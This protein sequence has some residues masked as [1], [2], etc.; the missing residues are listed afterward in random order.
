MKI[1]TQENHRRI[2]IVDDNPSIHSDFRKLLAEPGAE[3]AADLD[4]AA[5]DLFGQGASQSERPFFA[6]SSAFQGQEGL[7]KVREATASGQP[8]AVAFVD[9]RMPPGW[10]GIET[11]IRLWEADPDLQIVIC[12]AY[13]DYSWDGM[14][15]RLGCS[16]R[17][18]ILKKPFD[19]VEVLQLASALTEK[20]RLTQQVK[21]RLDDL[22]GMVRQRTQGLLELERQL[23]QA[24]KM[25][26]VGQLA[27]GVAHDFNNLLAVIRGN[28]E[29][30]LLSGGQVS[31]PVREHLDQ[32]IAAADRAANLTRQLLVFS[33]KQ[34]M[35]A[36]PLNLN[37]VI[38]NLTKML[39]RII[40]EDIELKC[41]CAPGLPLVLADAG[42]IEQVLVNLVVNARD[43]MPRG[44]QLVIGMQT[45]RVE[46]P[47]SQTHPENRAGDF[48]CLTVSDTGVGIAPEHLPRIFEP[49]FT[50]KEPGKGT[51]LGL[52]TVYGIVKQHQGWIEAS[53]EVGKGSVF[54][55]FL[56]LTNVPA[57][58]PTAGLAESNLRGG[59]ETILLVEDDESVRLLTR[60]VLENF[61]YR[62]QEATSGR[63]ALEC[64]REHVSEID[65]VLTDIIMPGGVSG[66]ELA[67][68]LQAC[69]PALKVVFMSGYSGESLGK[70]HG[71]MERTRGCFLQKPCTANSLLETVRR[72]LDKTGNGN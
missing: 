32:V 7:D 61:G 6:L 25:E 4:K 36:A 42:M 70:D 20:W 5:A 69:R 22:D 16:D 68:Q 59:S 58:A 35:Q 33:R 14:A 26:A 56:P 31:Q 63:K 24:Q 54:K 51:G 11:T 2:L 39:K 50:T 43:A 38:G 47:Q 60:R 40:G 12:T 29:L 45:A 48:A 71:F 1:K 21:R 34:A 64:W 23:R 67:E 18:V 52:A 13:S 41:D 17:L 19:S 53:S 66:R 28:T 8:F 30:A 72:C 9:V 57:S 46:K 27:G 15:E 55:I 49:F 10:D 3:E 62:V 37:D 65:L 44:G